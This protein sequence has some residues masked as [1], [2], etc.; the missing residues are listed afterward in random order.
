MAKINII[1]A[2]D[3]DIIHKNIRNT[4][5]S[6]DFD[7]QIIKDCY[8]TD[9]LKDYLFDVDDI[10]ESPDVLILDNLFFSSGEDTG[11]NALPDIR[12]AAPKLPILMLTTMGDDDRSFS[13]ARDLYGID[14]IQKPVRSSDLRFRIE[15]IIQKMNDWEGLQKKIL[16]DK[17]IM[18]YLT[19][20]YDKLSVDYD[21]V[22]TEQVELSIP[23]DMIK[24]IQ[25]IFPDVEI[26]P[27]AFRFLVKG[28]IKTAD[29]NKIF[30]CLKVIDWKDDNFRANGI[31]MDKF[32]QGLNWGYKNIWEY[33]FSRAG[34]IFVERR[35]Q[36]LP[37]IVL[38]DPNHNYSDLK[39]F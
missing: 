23:M 9:E 39:S 37:Q 20:E 21:K 36:Q 18:D 1:I 10:E 31:T 26:L 24:L 27:K 7:Y 15:S 34:R 13:D 16:E 17:E 38:I 4:L 35:E 30:R 19:S 2:D 32:T 25:S 14:Y 8:S 3:E 11:L 28:S 22:I 29:W 5:D 33:R 6:I 12:E